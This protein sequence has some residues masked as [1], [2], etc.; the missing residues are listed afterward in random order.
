MKE[1]HQRKGI[2]SALMKAVE[3]WANQR[4][5]SRLELSVMEHNDAALQLFKKLGFE[6]EGTRVNAI[7]LNDTFKAEYS[8]SKIL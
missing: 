5:I 1:E 7:K 6:H 8:L 2:G 4:N 3:D